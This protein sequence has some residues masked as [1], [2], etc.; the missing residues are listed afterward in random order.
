LKFVKR[1]SIKSSSPP[2]FDPEEFEEFEESDIISVSLE[3]ADSEEF[4][5]FEF[6]PIESTNL[7]ALSR[8]LGLIRSGNQE[9]RIESVL[10]FVLELEFILI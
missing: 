8:S 1:I 6:I 2:L 5:E 9:S 4:E 10:E 3:E 7:F